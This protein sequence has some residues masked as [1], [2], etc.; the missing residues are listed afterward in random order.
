MPK[1]TRRKTRSEGSGLPKKQTSPSAKKKDKPA[2][3]DPSTW[4]ESKI[5]PEEKV[6]KNN[7]IKLCI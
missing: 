1:V 6:G 5:D 3:T 4:P 7:A 2:A